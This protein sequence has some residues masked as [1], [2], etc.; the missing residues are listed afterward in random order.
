MP[1]TDNTNM[2]WPGLAKGFLCKETLGSNQTPWR[3][4]QKIKNLT[5][6]SN[7]LL[8]VQ[9][10]SN[11]W[12]LL[13]R[14]DIFQRIYLIYLSHGKWIHPTTRFWSWRNPGHMLIPKFSI[15]A[16][17]SKLC[18]SMVHG[19][20]TACYRDMDICSGTHPLLRANTLGLGLASQCVLGQETRPIQRGFF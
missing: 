17:A 13:M 7:Q 10:K 9:G 6:Y 8:E 3:N 4:P 12:K 15:L 18:W 1:V 19:L 5:K 20:T 14:S 16:L 11:P 2:S